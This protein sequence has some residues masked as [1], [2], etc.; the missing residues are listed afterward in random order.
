M[1][2]NH[3][4]RKQQ[5][6]PTHQAAPK[7]AGGHGKPQ[8]GHQ[9]DWPRS[10][11]AR[12][13]RPHRLYRHAT[14]RRRNFGRSRRRKIRRAVYLIHHVHLLD[15]RRGRKHQR[16][17]LVSAVC[18]ARPRIYG[19]PNPPRQRSQMLGTDAHR[20]LASTGPAPQRHQKRPVRTTQAHLDELAQLGHQA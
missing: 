20:R 17:V 18:D 16:P 3:L 12:G 15:R 1:D 5:R 8:S 11:N 7:S 10:Q 6:L 13:H 9:N 4:S 14:C 2:R 19:R